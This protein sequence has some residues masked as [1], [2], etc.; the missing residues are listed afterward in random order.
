MLQI[1]VYTHSFVSTAAPNRVQSSPL[2]LGEGFVQFRC[3]C[4]IPYGP[5]VVLQDVK[6]D[7]AVYPPFTEIRMVVDTK[8]VLSDPIKRLFIFWYQK[9][10][11]FEI[12]MR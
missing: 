11:N 10:E 1:T 7:Q 2:F 4:C 12:K 8:N 9:T 6:F 3:R 5:Q